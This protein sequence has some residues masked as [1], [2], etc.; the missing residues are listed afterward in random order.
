[1]TSIEFCPPHASP[2]LETLVVISNLLFLNVNNMFY[3]LGNFNISKCFQ[4]MFHKVMNIYFMGVTFIWGKSQF[5]SIF[6]IQQSEIFSKLLP[7]Y[8]LCVCLAYGILADSSPGLEC[9]C[10]YHFTRWREHTPYGGSWVPNCGFFF[11]I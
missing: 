8:T 2:Q 4:I 10:V 7:S 1:M 5:Y 11:Q 3:T 9:V 6:S